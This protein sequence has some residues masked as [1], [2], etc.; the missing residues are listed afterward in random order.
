MNIIIFGILLRHTLQACYE[1]LQGIT[2]IELLFDDDVAEATVSM[3][4]GKQQQKQQLSVTKI[5]R[6]TFSFIAPGNT[7]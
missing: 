2:T 3:V 7:Q 6:R 1:Y 4:T 5:D